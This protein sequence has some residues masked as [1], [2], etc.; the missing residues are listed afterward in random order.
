[1]RTL[2]LLFLAD[3]IQQYLKTCKEHPKREGVSSLMFQLRMEVNHR[4][5][6]WKRSSEH[7]VKW[8]ALKASSIVLFAEKDW[9]VHWHGSSSGTPPT[10]N[11]AIQIMLDVP[12]RGPPD[13][14]P[15]IDL[16]RDRS[17]FC[18]H[19]YR[20]HELWFDTFK[21]IL[22]IACLGRSKPIHEDIRKCLADELNDKLG[23]PSLYVF[24]ASN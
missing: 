1:M 8:L 16:W 5:L 24:L 2:S 17:A 15:F 12:C 13:A 10:C 18:L 9:L 11:W 6:T 19:A 14:L 20:N 22:I 21:W 4:Q 7:V 3:T 23:H